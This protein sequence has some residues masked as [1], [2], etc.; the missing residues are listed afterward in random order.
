VPNELFWT[1]PRDWF[2]KNV[3]RDLKQNGLI[4]PPTSDWSPSKVLLSQGPAFF[5]GG[6]YRTNTVPFLLKLKME[7][8]FQEKNS[9]GVRS[10]PRRTNT[11]KKL[12]D[13][14]SWIGRQARSCSRPAG[15]TAP[16]RPSRGIAPALRL[17]RR[18]PTQ[19]ACGSPCQTAT[20]AKR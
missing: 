18:D 19:G 14:M 10:S 11:S 1:S 6:I 20:P 3:E 17:H 8:D 13:S 15:R 7:A 5:I 12:S 9:T 4:V 2:K 16:R